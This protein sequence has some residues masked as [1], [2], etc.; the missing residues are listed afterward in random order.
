M[1]RTATLA[2]LILTLGIIAAPLFAQGSAPVISEKKEVAI[3]S[4]GY[5]GWNIPLETLGNIDIEIQKVFTD[6]GRFTISGVTQRLSAGGLEQFIATLKKAKEANF[7]MPEKYQFGEA[8]FT[9]AEFNSLTG[10]FIVAAPVV[11][12]FASEYNQKSTTWETS[13]KTNVT[14]IDVAA[15][16]TVMAIT[17]VQTSGTD[18]QSQNKSIQNAIDSI[19]MQLQF[20][21]RKIPAFQIN[22]RVLAI[23]GNEIKMQLGQDMGI[24]KGDEYSLIVGGMVEGF[25]DEREAGLVL[26]KNV[27]AQ[28]STGT[29]IYGG[30]AAVKDAQLREIPRMGV[31]MAPFLHIVTGQKIDLGGSEV[32]GATTI[33]GARMTMSRG[34]YDFRPFATV[35]LPV[36]GIATWGTIFIVPVNA[37]VGGEF[38]L[39][40]GRLS[41]TPMAAA[42]ISYLIVGEALS[43][44]TTDSSDS[45]F[46]HYGVQAYANVS[47]LL[48]RDIKLYGEA[49]FEYW[50]SAAPL[51]YSN[52]GG[53]GFGGGVTIKM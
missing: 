52:Y 41:I 45:F 36:N 31:D 28:V 16:G 39:Y 37:L 27:G 10:A 1:K 30:S 25:K 48:T 40:M 43:G 13:L 44:T 35:Q 53:I 49:G 29:I 11:S 22:T 3:F 26:I 21:I 20:E 18:K 51:L 19:P 24:K 12:N 2:A 5:F 17:E 8:I 42:G 46:S 38:N 9:E 4:L 23:S 47:W 34:F 14:F 50:L 7:V 33:V 32:T 15:G 6:L